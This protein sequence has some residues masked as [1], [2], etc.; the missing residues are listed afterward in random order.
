MWR[1]IGLVVVFGIGNFIFENTPKKR[2]AE[3]AEDKE[4][5]D[6]L[7][8]KEKLFKLKAEG[9]GRTTVHQDSV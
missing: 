7:N 5:Q 3:K 2:A 9:N 4:R 8:K 1:I 6:I